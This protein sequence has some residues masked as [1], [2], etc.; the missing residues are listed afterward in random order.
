MFTAGWMTTETMSTAAAWH[1][2]PYVS[3]V[4]AV[5]LLTTLLDSQGDAQNEK[6]TFAVQ[7]GKQATLI[8]ALIFEIM[9]LSIAYMI[10]DPVIFYPALFSA[11]LFFVPLFLDE[12]RHVER[13]IKYPILF[14]GL[15]VCVEWPS[16]IILLA[17]TFYLSKGYYKFRFGIDYPSFERMN[18]K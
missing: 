13:A 9:S 8:L 17:I 15:A 7:F 11:P 5:Y 12:I 14:L 4:A 6:I 3:A 18:K 2:I 16:F 10:E 1:A